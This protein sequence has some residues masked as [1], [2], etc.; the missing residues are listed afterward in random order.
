MEESTWK[1]SIGLPKS[2]NILRSAVNGISVYLSRLTPIPT[3]LLCFLCYKASNT[4]KKT[5][6]TRCFRNGD[7]RVAL[8]SMFLMRCSQEYGDLEL[9]DIWVC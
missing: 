6:F 9:Y 8:H 5:Y 3:S 1:F 2:G 4:S 7:I